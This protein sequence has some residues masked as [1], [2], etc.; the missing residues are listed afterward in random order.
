MKRIKLLWY[1]YFVDFVCKDFAANED[2]Y[3]DKPK[4]EESKLDKAF[5]KKI[6]PDTTKT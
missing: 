1:I 3:E 5:P 4:K 6:E 2:K